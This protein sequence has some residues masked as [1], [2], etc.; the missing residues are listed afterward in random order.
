[1]KKKIF[2]LS[3][4]TIFA[5]LFVN[6]QD[7]VYYSPKKSKKM[8][9]VQPVTPLPQDTIVDSTKFVQDGDT[10]ITNNYYNDE[11]YY[12]FQYSSR[13]KRFHSNYYLNSYYSDYYTNLYWYDYDPYDWGISIYFGYNFWDPYYYTP[14]HN[15]HYYGWDNWRWNRWHYWDYGW[16]NP[17]Y[18][19]H[20]YGHW[21][22]WNG[23]YGSGYW[24]KPYYNS[25]DN[26]S[27]FYIGHRNSVGGNLSHNSNYRTFGDKYNDINKRGTSIYGGDRNSRNIGLNP[28][29][30]NTQ[31]RYAQKPSVPRNEYQK[32]VIQKY[33]PPTYNQRRDRNEYETPAYRNNI[34]RDFGSERKSP[35]FEQSHRIQ[36]PQGA[37]ERITTPQKTPTQTQMTP[38][39][40]TYSPQKSYTPTPH[41]QK[42]SERITP[43]LQKT[44]E[45]ITP[46]SQR[47][48]TPQPSQRSTQS[49][50]NS[51]SRSTSSPSRSSR[52]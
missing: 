2:L 7:D 8:V 30:R 14:W 19:H 48:Y 33:S 37:P 3:I 46:P 49:S 42:T 26:N 22:Y 51:S 27:G 6:A 4:L 38:V 45:R 39:E 1:M 24:N 34:H 9:V 44:S 36:S 25:Y 15:P 40:R 43:P 31:Y 18:Y 17:Y 47:S 28:T 11:D 12:D 29:S 21:N 50:S 32:R 10:Y 16:Y 23:W 5:F 52:R 35:T 41:P 20:Y 13:L